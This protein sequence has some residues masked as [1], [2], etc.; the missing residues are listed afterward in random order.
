MCRPSE[1]TRSSGK[2]KKSLLPRAGRKEKR[3]NTHEKLRILVI[4]VTM[5][6]VAIVCLTIS[7]VP[8][9]GLL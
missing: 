1:G 5:M 4:V 2:R 8:V 9:R 7:L 6:V 3:E